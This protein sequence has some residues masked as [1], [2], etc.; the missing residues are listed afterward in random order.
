V[1]RYAQCERPDRRPASTASS[2]C[3][4]CA[5]SSSRNP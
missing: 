4:G 3:T 5:V 1:F 2:M